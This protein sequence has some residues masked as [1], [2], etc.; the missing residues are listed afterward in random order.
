MKQP[1]SG[2]M[3]RSTEVSRISRTLITFADSI[4]P[5]ETFGS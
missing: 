1:T 5:S 4:S 2:G 3:F